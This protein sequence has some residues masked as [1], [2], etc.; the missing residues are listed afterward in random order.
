VLR[1]TIRSRTAY[2]GLPFPAPRTFAAHPGP[3]APDKNATGSN[4]QAKIESLRK[5][6]E[7]DERLSDWANA[8]RDVGNEAAHNTNEQT[9]SQDA[10]DVLLLAEAL[11]DYIYTFRVPYDEF[12]QR[13]ATPKAPRRGRVRKTVLAVLP[14][15]T[16]GGAKEVGGA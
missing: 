5:T 14:D 9:T 15:G 3:C 2:K 16:L 4:L 11:A 10:G 1:R 7:I 6:G 12:V 8:L 13:R